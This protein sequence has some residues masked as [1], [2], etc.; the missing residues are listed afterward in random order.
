MQHDTNAPLVGQPQNIT[1]GPG[2]VN[3]WPSVA[4]DHALPMHHARTEAIASTVI[5]MCAAMAGLML[6]RVRE[7]AVWGGAWFLVLVCGMILFLVR[8]QDH[9]GYIRA[10]RRPEP[11][12]LDLDADGQPDRVRAVWYGNGAP[13]AK[14]GTLA[15]VYS[16]RFA[17]FIVVC[18][19]VGTT[20]RALRSAGFDDATQALFQAWLLD[21]NHPA[22]QWVSTAGHTPGW[23]LLD[24]A[25]IRKVLRC[26]YWQAEST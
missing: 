17:A 14:S 15:A 20:V 4:M 1:T 9:V 5:A 10:N 26:T 21:P 25:M 19:Q 11:D 18:Q 6:L 3:P 2:A 23:E 16:V 22:A 7:L 24:E 8:Y 12:A 13:A